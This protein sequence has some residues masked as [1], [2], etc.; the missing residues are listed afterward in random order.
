MN[1]K[2]LPM[3][4]P[5]HQGHDARSI[6]VTY[7]DLPF[8]GSAMREGAKGYRTRNGVNLRYWSSGYNPESTWPGWGEAENATDFWAGY[9]ARLEWSGFGV[10]MHVHNHLLEPFD[11]AMYFSLVGGN[12]TGRSSMPAFSGTWRGAAIATPGDMSFIADGSVKLTITGDAETPYGLQSMF[13]M[14]IGDWQG[15]LLNDG[16]I[17]S[18]TDVPIGDIEIDGYLA[19]DVTHNEIG[20]PVLNVQGQGSGFFFNGEFFGPSGEEVAGTFHSPV[21]GGCL[22]SSPRCITGVF[23]ARLQPDG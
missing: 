21:L 2:I 7:D 12:A 18:I 14:S 16:E 17:G 1:Y 11:S 5:G 10:V 9:G 20:V 8:V 4:E 15:Y 13:N 3:R 6:S 19:R 23:G 22:G